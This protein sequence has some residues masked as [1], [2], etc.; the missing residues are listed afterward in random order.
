[1]KKGTVI[2]YAGC[3][4]AIPGKPNCG[5]GV[6]CDP[7]MTDHCEDFGPMAPIRYRPAAPQAEPRDDG[8]RLCRDEKCVDPNCRVPQHAAPA[9]RPAPHTD[10]HITSIN[11]AAPRCPDCGCAMLPDGCVN[12]R[13]R[14]MTDPWRWVPWR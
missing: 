11:V 5:E 10:G 9:P 8:A 6:L 1:M 7:C 12:C 14:A 13:P 3:G 4:R 2:N